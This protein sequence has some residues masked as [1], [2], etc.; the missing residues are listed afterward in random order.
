M[1][2]QPLTSVEPGAH[3]RHLAEMRAYYER[4]AAQYFS[5]HDDP[6]HDLAVRELIALVKARGYRSVLDVCCGPG[7]ALK[8]CLA[9]GIEA[10]GVDASQSMMDEGIKRGLPASRFTCADATN[11]PFN[12]KQFDVSCVNG[13]LHHCLVPEKIIQEMI[14]VTRYALV[15]S[16]EG[17]HL[18]GGLK[19]ILQKLGI[20]NVAYRL[21]FRRPPRTTRRG[22]VSEGDGP[23]FAFSIEEVAPLIV[24]NFPAIKRHQ[25]YRL[26]QRRFVSRYLPRLFARNVVLI[27]ETP[28]QAS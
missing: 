19:V 5:L 25:W 11:L 3:E 28:A 4:T 2:F 26:G 16:D 9:E 10:C 27:A 18:H 6:E 8:A 15:I 23:A 24:A 21:V 7:R 22:S 12:D 17:N 13:A 14:R 1:T 20:F